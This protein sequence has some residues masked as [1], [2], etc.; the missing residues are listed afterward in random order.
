MQPLTREL[1][2]VDRSLCAIVCFRYPYTHFFCAR[3]TINKNVWSALL[4]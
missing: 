1:A 2:K 4:N 3:I